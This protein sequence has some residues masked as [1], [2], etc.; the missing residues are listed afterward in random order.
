[1]RNN[2]YYTHPTDTCHCGIAQH[3]FVSCYMLEYNSFRQNYSLFS[4]FLKNKE[5]KNHDEQMLWKSCNII[6]TV[7]WLCL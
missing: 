5:T 1:M 4:K 3:I 2:G 6:C 7:P